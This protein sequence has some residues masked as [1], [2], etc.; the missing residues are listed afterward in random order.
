MSNPHIGLWRNDPAMREG[1]YPVLLRRDGTIP[2]WSYFVIGAM[3]AAAPA[4]LWAY[5]AE[6]RRMGMAPAYAEDVYRLGHEF[7]TER[8]DRIAAK[9]RPGD[10]DKGPHRKDDPLTLQ[11]A[12]GEITMAGIAATLARVQALERE[13]E[14][15]RLYGNKDCTEMADERLKQVEGGE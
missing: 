15:L 12:R 5:A 10:P 6:A 8:L 1:K 3:D 4:A 7:M 11:L 9:Q 13:V 14:V 2:E